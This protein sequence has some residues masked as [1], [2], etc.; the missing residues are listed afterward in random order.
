MI[1]ILIIGLLLSIAIPQMI[2]ARSNASKRTCQKNMR[3]YDCAKA[4][5]AIDNNLPDTHVVVI[6][7]VAPYLK[8]IPQCPMGGTYDLKT[9]GEPTTCSLPEH[10][11]L[12]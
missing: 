8:R 11:S 5:C 4:Q 12:D 3:D 1:T 6:G 2:T 9:V 10:P 7:D